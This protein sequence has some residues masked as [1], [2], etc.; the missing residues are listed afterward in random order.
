MYHDNIL[1]YMKKEQVEIAPF[2]EGTVDEYY[3]LHHAVKKEE[4]REAKWRIVFDGSSHE[5]HTLSLN[6]ALEMGPNLLPK[7]LATL[8]RFRLYIVGIIGNIGQAFLHLS[9][10][11]RDKNL[12]RF[13]WYRVTKDED[14]NYDTT[15]EIVR[16]VSLCLT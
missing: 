1:D 8:L 15:R 9:L 13:F 7:I 3:L 6:D 14:G 4:R 2:E 10:N 16:I 12:T 5:D 11:K